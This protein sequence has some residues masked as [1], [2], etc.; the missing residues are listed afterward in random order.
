MAPAHSTGR[1]RKRNA[2]ADLVDPH[3]A[4]CQMLVTIAQRRRLWRTSLFFLV[5][6]A[7]VLGIYGAARPWLFESRGSMAYDPAVGL[8]IEVESC[9]VELVAGGAARVVVESRS[10]V[11]APLLTPLALHEGSVDGRGAS[12]GPDTRIAISGG[13]SIRLFDVPAYSAEASLA[14]RQ[15]IGAV[16]VATDLPPADAV[17]VENEVGDPWGACPLGD[18]NAVADGTFAAVLGAQYDAD[19]DAHVSASEFLQAA[20]RIACCGPGAPHVCSCAA[21]ARD[22]GADGSPLRAA[23]L[24]DDANSAD[25]AASSSSM[26]ATAFAVGAQ[27]AE[28][29]AEDEQ[30]RGGLVRVTYEHLG[31]SRRDRTSPTYYTYAPTAHG[32]PGSRRRIVYSHPREAGLLR[33]TIWVAALA[34]IAFGVILLFVTFWWLRRIQQEASLTTA[35]RHRAVLA[36]HGIDESTIRAQLA[37]DDSL[38]AG[39]SG[40]ASLFNGPVRTL[41]EVFDRSIA[42]SATILVNP[43]RLKVVDS[44]G[45]FMRDQLHEAPVADGEAELAR[46]DA[47]RRRRRQQQFELQRQKEQVYRDAEA[48]GQV[49]GASE[50]WLA[51]ERERERLERE[52]ADDKYR[53]RYRAR[54][55]ISISEMLS[56]Y[57]LYCIGHGYEMSADADTLQRA[58]TKKHV[59]VRQVVVRQLRGLKW[60]NPREPLEVEKLRES[61]FPVELRESSLF[62]HMP[63]Y[64]AERSAELRRRAEREQVLQGAYAASLDA[65]QSGGAAQL[66]SMDAGEMSKNERLPTHWFVLRRFIWQHCTVEPG[67]LHS[68][69]LLEDWCDPH[70]EALYRHTRER[71]TKQQAVEKERQRRAL[72]AEGVGAKLKDGQ[73]ASSIAQGASFV[74]DFQSVQRDDELNRVPKPPPLEHGFRTSLY[75]YCRAEGLALPDLHGT[76]WANQLPDGVHFQDERRV[77]Y[78]LG[79]VWARRLDAHVPIN[80]VWLLCE[81]AV[82]LVQ[83]SLFVAS[84][85]VLGYYPLDAL[86]M[87]AALL[88]VPD[89]PGYTTAEAHPSSFTSG[90]ANLGQV[91]CADLAA[92]APVQLFLLGDSAVLPLVSALV[93]ECCLASLVGMLRLLFCYVNPPRFEKGRADG[94]V[95]LFGLVNLVYQ[96][97]SIVFGA[98]LSVHLLLV[99]SYAGMVLAWH[100]LAT[101]SYP[102]RILR[103]TAA[104]AAFAYVGIG[105]GHSMLGVQ[106]ALRAKLE[107]AF[108]EALQPALRTAHRRA[109]AKLRLRRAAAVGDGS[110]PLEASQFRALFESLQ[111]PLST[112][113]KE[114]LYSQVEMECAYAFERREGR[115]KK[116]DGAHEHTHAEVTSVEFFEAWEAMEQSF[117]QK[118]V[119]VAGVSNTKIV[120]ELL[121]GSV[122]LGALILIIALGAQ[123]FSADKTDEFGAVL[124]AIVTAFCGLA[125]VALRPRSTGE[126]S[127]AR[128]EEDALVRQLITHQLEQA[129]SG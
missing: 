92:F 104:L 51:L 79:L 110:N 73:G 123:S 12:L 32:A 84:P 109:Q 46:Q 42:T 67:A 96:G 15:P 91:S 72:A 111:L 66:A 103:Q 52:E 43:L 121:G 2:D 125:V 49:A 115:R 108:L 87:W 107:V 77:R 80:F 68:H 117:L 129:A 18:A 97:M 36:R 44:V 113:Q 89:D 37:L 83:M 11:D 24:G 31:T 58:L 81:V 86:S 69:V 85:L 112:S 5:F 34:G 35:A 50:E 26:A 93:L 23:L 122:I 78:A 22:L 75:E 128:G 88:C 41:L 20:E 106:A 39:G 119:E 55:P 116:T 40:I 101:F 48:F 13:G 8:S 4:Y 62:G 1:L 95:G 16:C 38:I 76:G 10:G 19:G 118:C 33:S 99:F 102:V 124:Q 74:D 105:I 56:Q 30:L 14:L 25:A 120:V 65:F 126:I 94:L 9:D 59:P 3:T 63:G 7:I 53:L 61:D 29:A 98:S 28:D 90:G 21:E 57:E 27:N 82:V 64:E 45:R 127:Y 70:D 60:K 114:M 47:A 71:L 17:I 100:V 6:M 54:R